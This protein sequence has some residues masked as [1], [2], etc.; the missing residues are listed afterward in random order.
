MNINKKEQLLPIG[1]VCLLGNLNLT[2]F[3]KEDLSG[4]DYEKLSKVIPVAVRF[5]DNVN[6]LTY[7]PLEDQKDNLMN[8][9]RIGLG[10]LGY[11]SALLIMKKRYGSPDAIQ[12]TEELM[13][14][15]SNTAYQ[16]SALLAKEKGPFLLYDEEKYLK[17][18]YLKNLSDE[19]K[20]LIKKHGIRNSHLLS[21]QPTGNCVRKN[22]IIKTGE[23]EMTIDQIFKLN[24]I[25]INKSVKNRWYIPIM[26]IKA[27]TIDGYS[28]ITGM[29]I[30]DKKDILSIKTKN[31]NLI[32]GTLEHKVLVKVSDKEAIWK[33]LGD[34]KVGDKIL[35]KKSMEMAVTPVE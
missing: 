10:I 5:M 26:D 31:D 8:K 19:T 4:W 17:S 25:N 6:D 11:G 14:F 27:E 1:G 7:V 33:N 13:S 20:S 35:K 3:I 22:T 18:E 21:V 24:K 28:R 32:E 30:N 15:I 12:Q 34:L 29:Y 9:R 2:Q 23:G 16:S